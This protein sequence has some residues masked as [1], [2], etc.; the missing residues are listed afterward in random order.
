MDIDLFVV[1]IVGTYSGDTEYGGATA[2]AGSDTTVIITEAV[3]VSL[4]E[5]NIT[6]DDSVTVTEDAQAGA[7]ILFVD[8]AEDVITEEYT[9]ILDIE[10]DMEAYEDVA[11]TSVAY[12]V[13]DALIVIVHEDIALDD[14]QGDQSL[15]LYIDVVSVVT[16]TESYNDLVTVEC[17]IKSIGALTVSGTRQIDLM[18]LVP[19][20]FRDSDLLIGYIEMFGYFVGQWIG[21]IE[22]MRY[23]IDPYRVSDQLRQSIPGVPYETFQ[24]YMSHLASLI[25][26]IIDKS[27]VDPLDPEAPTILR[28]QLLQAIDWYKLKGTYQAMSSAIY[29]AGQNITLY[30]F[31]TNDYEDI[32]SYVETAWFVAKTVGE[33][34]PE[35]MVLPNPDT[36]FKTPHFGLQI[37][38]TSYY[39]VPGSYFLWR[40]TDGT[41]FNQVRKVTEQ[42]R[43]ANTVPHFQIKAAGSCNED[44]TLTTIPATLISTM[45]VYPNWV[46][47]A[48]YF[49]HHNLGAGYADWNFDRSFTEPLTD[50]MFDWS[51]AMYKQLTRWRLGD[52]SK[53]M[54]PAPLWN[55]ENPVLDGIV[56]DSQIK[57][58]P[59]RTEYTITVPAAAAADGLSEGGL[60]LPDVSPGVEGDIVIGFTFPDIDKTAGLDLRFIITMYK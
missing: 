43:P 23:L 49:D 17:I 37:D 42:V 10:I 2:Y 25:G 19:E 59:D 30:D 26:L 58:Y 31:Y 48:M 24:A 33:L 44:G 41:K 12:V 46:F 57:P 1:D 18:P 21:R 22:D 35:V 54:V 3:S 9:E 14:V 5:L 45:R 60:F 15:Q 20:K 40:D 4:T 29:G 8:V 56:D 38:L 6:S 53:N 27:D 34:P 36:Y 39:G 47:T 51:E 13:I 55:L 16:I 28:R 50:V 52:G 32:N 7:A 11:A